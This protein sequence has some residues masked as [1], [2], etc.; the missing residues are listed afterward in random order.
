MKLRWFTVSRIDVALVLCLTAGICAMG[1]YAWPNLQ[2]LAA[3]DSRTLG[4]PCALL[5]SD[6]AD[7]GVLSKP[8]RATAVF[9]IRNTGDQRLILS[10]QSTSCP[11]ASAGE[12]EII[13]APRARSE[14]SV[15]IDTDELAGAFDLEVRYQTNDALH[16]LLTFHILADVR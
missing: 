7:V 16:P 13:V 10:K 9:W 2:A 14:I 15:A 8:A 3:N 12:K 1:I 4:P 5:E 11:C 6:R